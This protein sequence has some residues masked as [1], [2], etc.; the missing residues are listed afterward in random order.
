MSSSYVA[1][2]NVL[3]QRL[4]DLLKTDRQSLSSSTS[5][6]LLLNPPSSFSLLLS[7]LLFDLLSMATPRCSGSSKRR[8]FLACMWKESFS[9]PLTSWTSSARM[10]R[11]TDS[12]S[13]ASLRRDDLNRARKMWSTSARP[14]AS[15]GPQSVRTVKSMVRGDVR[16]KILPLIPPPVILETLSVQN[17]ARLHSI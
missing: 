5:S 3:T 12:A 7:L 11:C 2:V 15:G 1:T 4:G 17:N 14:V 6:Y 16:A 8:R 9:R 10:S 13:S